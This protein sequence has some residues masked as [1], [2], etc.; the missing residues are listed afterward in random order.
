MELHR[1]S[2]RHGLGFA[3]AATTMVMWGMLPLALK[4]VLRVTDS[5]TI[6][7]FRFLVSA[8]IVGALLAAKGRLPRFSGLGR[9]GWVLLLLA[10]G[11]LG[12]NYITYMIGL[13]LTTPATS[14]IVIQL[15][16]PLLA[17]GG[18]FV[19]RER[20]SVA[21]WI[22]FATLLGGL[23]LFFWGQIAR[24]LADLDRYYVGSAWVVL[25]AVTW[26]VYGL[27]QKQLL[28]RLGSQGIMLCVYVVCAVAFWPFATPSDLVALGTVELG[29][30]AFTALN[31][32]I[33][34]GAFA[35]ALAHWE[36]SRVSAVLALTPLATIGFGM[37]AS[38]LYPE[39]FD[40]DPVGVW[41][42]VGAVLVVAGSVATALFGRREPKTA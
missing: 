7:W 15:S 34:Y 2:G 19:F 26:A 28:V 36:A 5:W 24:F 31:T 38:H 1:S 21:Q 12:A 18:L 30:L 20:F 42:V 10:I 37:T 40:S 29:L 3:L 39:W 33:A 11:G 23:G 41:G 17:L 35:E 13:D 8:L 4:A 25:A 22:G 16:P 27:A 9:A 6:V 32:T 14:Q